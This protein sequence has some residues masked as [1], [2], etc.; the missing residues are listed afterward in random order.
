MQKQTLPLILNEEKN[1]NLMYIC[2]CFL[3]QIEASAGEEEWCIPDCVP[4]IDFPVV[5]P[6]CRFHC[7]AAY[8]SNTV[9][10]SGKFIYSSNVCIPG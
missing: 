10:H 9:K 1:L 3:L 2:L 6:P 7:P 4:D 5:V 8:I